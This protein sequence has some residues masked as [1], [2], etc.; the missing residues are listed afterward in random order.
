MPFGLVV[1]KIGGVPELINAEERVRMDRLRREGDRFRFEIDVYDVV[2]DARLDGERLVG[3]WRRRAREGT[4]KLPFEATYGYAHR[5]S[6]AKRT[7]RGA[8]TVAVGAADQPEGGGVPKSVAGSWTMQF[9]D[10][11][12]PF[13][14]L[15]ELEQD[16]DKVTGTILT[17][18][19]D[20]RYLEGDYVDGRLRL[21]TFD[22]AHA[23]LFTAD[24]QADGSLKGDWWSRDVYHA[25][26]TARRKG[27][28]D[29]LDNPYEVVSVQDE[30]R[31]FVFKFPDVDGRMVASDDPRFAGQVVVID[32]FGTWCP[33]CGDLAIVLADWHKK[34][35]GRGLQVVG[36][37]FEFTDDVDIANRQLRAYAARYGIEF[38]LLRAGVSDKDD[39]ASRLPSIDKVKAYPTMVFVGR[40]G[41]VSKVHSGFAGPATGDRYTRMVAELEGEI[42]RLLAAAP[43]AVAP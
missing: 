32:I 30:D 41:R 17:N 37:A 31:R 8:T 5:F 9:V 22:A 39:A 21:S 10:E 13:P 2:L 34:Y 15:A 36:L 20:H 29:T 28:E 18:T 35:G 7:L 1:P 11:D 43:D 42:E 19:G 12:G 25:T 3:Q 33:N 24:A 23:F 14:A 4:S 26:F 27:A 38:P 6:P 40:D 16:G